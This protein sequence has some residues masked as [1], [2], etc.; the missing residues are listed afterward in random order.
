[1]TARSTGQEK[2]LILALLMLRAS[3]KGISLSRRTSEW[4]TGHS[5]ALMIAT[6]H[7]KPLELRFFNFHLG[8]STRL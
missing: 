4:D 5:H 2:T 1:M 8:G 7:L 6:W 3:E